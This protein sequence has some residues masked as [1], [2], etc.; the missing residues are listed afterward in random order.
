[1]ICGRE[2]CARNTDALLWRDFE[3]RHSH[4]VLQVAFLARMRPLLPFHSVS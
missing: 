2:V 1:M 3:L 4:V